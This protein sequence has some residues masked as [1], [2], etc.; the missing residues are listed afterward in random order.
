MTSVVDGR[1]V[2]DVPGHVAHLDRRTVG[3]QLHH[4][5]DGVLAVRQA[6]VGEDD[7]H[8]LPVEFAQ[9]GVHVDPAVEFR[10]N[11][12]PEHVVQ[13]GALPGVVIHNRDTVH[14]FP[15]L[16]VPTSLLH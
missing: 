9:T 4:L 16:L 15:F 5:L 3:E 12:F 14:D 13:A 7:V 6:D 2:F 10:G 11:E 1:A 8:L